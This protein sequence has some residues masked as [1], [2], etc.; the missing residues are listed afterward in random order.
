[1]VIILTS[2]RLLLE[3]ASDELDT[4]SSKGAMSPES[5]IGSSTELLSGVADELLDDTADGE[6]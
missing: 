5:A 4:G 2:G 1:M 3:L 6:E